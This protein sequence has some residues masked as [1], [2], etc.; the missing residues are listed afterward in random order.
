[1]GETVSE[2]A[3]G[4]L[5]SAKEKLGSMSESARSAATAA[6][7]RAGELIGDARESAHEVYE[8]ARERVTSWS[9]DGMQYVRENPAKSVFTALLAGVVLGITLRRH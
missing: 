5:S 6:R 8:R 3:S 1:M 2:K 4:M 7:D 9:E